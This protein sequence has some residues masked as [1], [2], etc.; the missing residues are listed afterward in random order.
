[1]PIAHANGI[2][3]DYDTFGEP[4]DPALVLIMGFSVQKIAWDVEFCEQLAARGFFVVRF[5]NRDIG[6]STKIEDGPPPNLAAALT[7]DVSSASYRLDDMADDTAG[8][9][10]AI[11]L[12]AA[13]VVGASMGGMIAQCL[14]INHPDKVL[15]LCSIMSTTG[16]TKVG[17]AKPEAM[18]ALLA[19][20]PQTRDE[21][22]QRTVDVTKV[23]GS[24]AYPTDEAKIRNRSGQAWDRGHDAR[25]VARQLLAILASPDRTPRLG[26]LTMPALV[27][28]GEADPLIDQSGAR[29]TAEAIP[30]AELLVIPG[31][32]HDLPQQLWPQIVDAIVAN[33][34]R[35]SAPSSR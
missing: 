15:S 4:A 30:G 8:L 19:P 25:G 21:A 7:G 23:I 28:H 2:D 20:P 17:Q 5:D 16:N 13:H 35:A 12:P 33:A 26:A 27:I 9:L 10:D 18:A 24:P 34:A 3:L 22:M 11:G 1:M 32:G 6:R 14:A 29:A 31:M